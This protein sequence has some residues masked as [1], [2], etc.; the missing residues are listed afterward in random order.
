MGAPKSST[1]LLG[2]ARFKALSSIRKQEDWIDDDDMAQMS[3]LRRIVEVLP[4]EHRTVIDLAY[5][6]GRSVTEIGE[7]LGIRPP[8]SSPGCS[9]PARNSA[10]P[11]RIDL[12]LQA[13]AFMHVVFPAAAYLGNTLTLWSTIRDVAPRIGEE[14]DAAADRRNI[15]WLMH[16][17]HAAAF[18]LGDGLARPLARLRRHDHR[19][20]VGL[21]PGRARILKTGA[22]LNGWFGPPLCPSATAATGSNSVA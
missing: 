18:Q 2:I 19:R 21:S 13:S 1:W 10:R 5:R 8:L 6:H 11:E 22:H 17:C 16:N 7:V 14:R 9:T 3:A 4:E 20:S 12:A 15:E